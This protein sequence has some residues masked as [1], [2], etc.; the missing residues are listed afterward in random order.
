[1]R[2]AFYSWKGGFF[3]M[4]R[5]AVFGL[6]MI[7]ILPACAGRDEAA[8]KEKYA[9]LTRYAYTLQTWLTAADWKNAVDAVRNG[10]SNGILFKNVPGF[11]GTRGDGVAL[12]NQIKQDLS[13]LKITVFVEGGC[14]SMCAIA[15]AF[16]AERHIIPT[17]QSNNP[18]FVF[19]HSAFHGLG[20]RDIWPE[21]TERIADDIASRWAPLEPAILEVFRNPKSQLS[22]LVIV[23]QSGL[24]G[25]GHRLS[26][27]LCDTDQP[28]W[29]PQ[30]C[31]M[32]S[33]DRYI[34]ADVQRNFGSR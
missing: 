30:D 32:L 31:R 5:L 7:M 11:K 8:D 15:F 12:I 1:M 22:G 28:A 13:Q 6:V 14:A 20:T 3:L 19:F 25:S 2:F 9:E 21:D 23:E 26:A 16:G 17:F 10:K 33:A 4:L 24:M 18:S 34:P 27:L 29:S